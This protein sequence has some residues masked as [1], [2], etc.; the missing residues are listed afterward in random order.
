MA[1]DILIKNGIVVDGVGT[2][3]YHADVAI[4]NGKIEKIGFL[5]EPSAEITIDATDQYVAP[6][7]IDINN[8][9]DRHWTL[10]SHPNSE[11]YLRQGVTTIIGGNCGSS[12]APLTTGNIIS[13]IQKW[14]DIS[15]INVNWLTVKEFFEELKRKK[16]ALNF[17][18]LV[19]HATL[20]R[21]I[22]GDEFRELTEKE[23]NQMKHMLENAQGDGALGFST[24]LAYSHAKVATLDEVASLVSTLWPGKIYSSHLRDEE[25]KLYES[26]LEVIDIAKKTKVGVEISHFKATLKN[27]FNIFDKSLEAIEKVAEEGIDINFDIYPYTS[28]ATVLYTI[29]PHWVAVGGRKKLIENLKNSELRKRVVE[30]MRG[31]EEDFSNIIIASGNI[32]RTFIGKTIKIISQN[33]GADVLE[34]VM[35]LLIVSEGKLIVFWPCLSEENF[36]KALKSSLSIIASDG[37]AYNLD[38]ARQGYLAHPRSFGCFPKILSYYV[39]EKNTI[40]LEDAIKKMTALPALKLGLSNRGVIKSGFFADITIFDFNTIK[41]LAT[42]ENPFQYAQ[43]INSVII[44]GQLALSSG[45]TVNQGVGQLITN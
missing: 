27:N 14:A 41:D 24:G 7:F 2:P 8:A 44:N 33:Q 9:S 32:D 37:A 25:S 5:G 39:H 19:G 38:D 1:L 34:T 3:A 29:L 22:V 31:R 13:S 42:F 15:H 36:I 6:G 28:T 43:G 40:D 45:K 23:L 10:F 35:N 12:L 30:E 20:R 17:G 16:L 18:T 21:S 4:K 11:S 26:V